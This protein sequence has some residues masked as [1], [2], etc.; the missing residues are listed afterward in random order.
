MVRF[1]K[2]RRSITTYSQKQ[3]EKDKKFVDLDRIDRSKYPRIRAWYIVLFIFLGFL[4]L[5]ARFL[6]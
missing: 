3:E 4:Y 1:R 5:I 2:K 6:F